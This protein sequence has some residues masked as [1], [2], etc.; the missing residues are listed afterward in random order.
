MT[1]SIPWNNVPNDLSDPSMKVKTPITNPRFAVGYCRASKEDQRL[2]AAAQR[3][4]IEGWATR[5][6]VSVVAW[7][8]DQDVCS[9]TSLE[10]RPGLVS[11]MASIRD[12][13]AGLLIIAK[14]DRL[15][16]D[17]V[18]AASIERAVNGL[19]ARVVSAAGE[20]NGDGPSD[21]FMRGVIDCVSQYER[22]LIR[23]RTKAA[24]AVKSDRG[25]RVGSIPFG[26]RVK[27]DGATL[28]E[29]VIEQATI[30]EAKLLTRRGL[31]YRETARTLASSG[32]LSR[33]GRPF[34]ATQIMRMVGY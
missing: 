30:L 29:D 13:S 16:R 19:G 9:V 17:V 8:T 15:A 24:L 5:E 31:S 26:F 33:R 20:G 23:S 25:E 34:Q 1:D 14:R 7:H 6:G 27:D 18:L 32:R 21:L 4:A 12:M 2:T 3:A 22:D 11:A 10:E 28:E